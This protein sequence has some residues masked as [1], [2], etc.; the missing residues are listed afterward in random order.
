MIL[1]ITSAAVASV[2]ELIRPY[3]RYTPV[4]TVDRGLARA[5]A[6]AAGHQAGAV[7]ALGVV[8]G[9]R[10]VRQPAAAHGPAGRGG[11]GFR[12]EPRCGGGLR[13]PGRR[14]AGQDLR[15]EVSSPAKIGRIRGYGA[16]LVVA[17]ASYDEARAASEDWAAS[18]GALQVPAFDQAET[19]LGAGSLATELRE[20]VPDATAVLASVGGGGLLAGICAGYPGQAGIIGVEPAGAP[21]LTRALAAGQPVDAEVGSLAVDSLAPRRVGQ[22]TFAVLRD[23]IQ[24]VLLVSDAEIRAAQELLWDRLRL[25]AEPGGC[26][27]LAAV[28]S[29][30]FTPGPGRA[31]HRRAQ[32][33]Q[34]DRRRLQP[35][36]ETAAGRVP[37]GVGTRPA[38]QHPPRRQE[39]RVGQGDEL[40]ELC[41]SCGWATGSVAAGL[42]VAV[43]AGRG[44]GWAGRA[45][46]AARSRTG[47]G[48]PGWSRCWWPSRPADGG[49]PRRL[50]PAPVPAADL[51]GRAVPVL[52]R[53]SGGWPCGARRR[54]W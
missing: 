28:L 43:P 49:H 53:R 40:G 15:P 10:G 18:S 24:Q 7:A 9:P 5:G 41:G 26:A 44:R 20:Q 39:R 51:L 30:R 42:A 32:R 54:P 35:L 13:G 22:R 27:A 8:Q 11:G 25:V 12:R 45:A 52:R 50:L 48:W 46:R 37:G 14:G 34:H 21:T 16:D 31:G 23:G 1:E 38:A 47:S 33:G 29:G 19:I 4:I 3:I 17:G 6:R 36:S 2:A